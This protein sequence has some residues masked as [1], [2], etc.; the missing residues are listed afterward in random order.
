MPWSHGMANQPA[1]TRTVEGIE[2][3]LLQPPAVRGSVLLLPLQARTPGRGWPES[4][5]IVLND[6][7]AI[8]GAVIWIGPRPTSPRRNWTDDPAGL[9]WRPISPADDTSRPLDGGGP[10]LIVELPPDV[11]G[12]VAVRERIAESRGTTRQDSPP[13][14][15]TTVRPLWFDP[16]PEIDATWP[17]LARTF[18]DDRPDPESPFDHW[19][20]TLLAMRLEQTP[21]P[22]PASELGDGAAALI[23]RHAADLWR[24]GF[25]RLAKQS[26]GVAAECLE[27][28]TNI[29]IDDDGRSIAVWVTDPVETATLLGILLDRTKSERSMMESALA[30]AESRRPLTTWTLRESPDAIVIAIANARVEPQTVTFDWLTSAGVATAPLTVE[31]VGRR[32]HRVSLLRPPIPVAEPTVSRDWLH[33]PMLATIVH[34]G[35]LRRIPVGAASIRVTPPGATFGTF[36]PALRL[37]D[38]RSGMQEPLPPNRQTGAMLRRVNRRWEVF[39]ECARPFGEGLGGA[40]ARASQRGELG[41][42]WPPRGVEAITLQLGDPDAPTAILCVPERGEWWTPIGV[43]AGLSVHR[44]SDP[45]FWRCRIVLPPEWLPTSPLEPLRL[46]LVRTHGDHTG[47][48]TAGL[49]R[50]AWSDRPAPLT[51]DL[52]RWEDR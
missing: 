38:V 25:A 37:A 16:A 43:A 50:P 33:T 11:T 3:A 36:W 47:V 52:S 17:P 19:R 18:A 28:L 29:A 35:E 27:M 8:D 49:P 45:V 21:P 46:G 9:A 42:Q 6:G 24:V 4:L 14:L 30:W 44:S 13:P 26:T 10:Y 34:R 31:L 51:F 7:S 41:D 22:P 40:D 2:P 32:L 1:A 20:W 23:A 15:T 39:V 12:E 5:Q 48:E